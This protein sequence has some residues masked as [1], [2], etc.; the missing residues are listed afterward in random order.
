MNALEA[1]GHGLAGGATGADET[2]GHDSIGSHD[3][4]PRNAGF[5]DNAQRRN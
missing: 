3:E 1:A 4:H 5:G 2:G